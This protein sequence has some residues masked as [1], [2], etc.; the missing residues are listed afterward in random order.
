M[1][2]AIVSDHRTLRGMEIA[3]FIDRHGMASSRERHWSG[4]TVK[5]I[6]VS[7]GPKLTNWYDVF[8]YKG[9]DYRIRY[10]D[11]CFHP[12]VTRLDADLPKFV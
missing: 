11:G 2:K 8:N 7:P 6:T 4:A 3:G 1:A 5:V 9:V 12:F 10:F